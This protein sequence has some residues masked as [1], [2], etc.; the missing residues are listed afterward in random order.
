MTKTSQYIRPILSGYIMVFNFLHFVFFQVQYIHYWWKHYVKR[1]R[2]NFYKF[3]MEF[4][5]WKD[6]KEVGTISFEVRIP[7]KKPK[8]FME[9]FYVRFRKI[10]FIFGFNN[11]I[12]EAN[13]NIYG[14]AVIP[15][16][17]HWKIGLVAKSK[18]CNGLDFTE[19]P[20]T[21]ENRI[22][23]C[24]RSKL[25]EIK[26]VQNWIFSGF[27]SNVEMKSSSFSLL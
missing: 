20:K 3:F 15:S 17:S 12:L 19:F 21:F 23:K 24:A 8:I 13:K 14:N 16:K 4:I 26:F 9:F 10:I 7:M 1:L 2:R 11:F 6:N 25:K 5:N 22:C 27:E 18:Q